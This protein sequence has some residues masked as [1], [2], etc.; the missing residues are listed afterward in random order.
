M[1]GGGSKTTSN[2]DIV[3]NSIISA[4]ISSAQSCT[5]GLT[6]NQTVVSSGL[7]LFT[8]TAQTATVSL[9][10]LQKVVVDDTLLTQ[11]AQQ[12]VQNVQAN[13]G[14]LFGGSANS[15]ANQS[16]K[17]YLQTK[18]T[19]SFVQTC[20]SSISA[21]QSVTTSGVQ[22]GTLDEQTVSTVQ[23]CL[24]NALNSNNVAQGITTDTTQTGAAAN[25]GFSLS[26]GSLGSIGSYV[27]YFIVFIVLIIT[28]WYIYKYYSS[29]KAKTPTPER[30]PEPGTY[31]PE[32][33]TEHII[34]PVSIPTLESL[35]TQEPVQE[36][37]SVSSP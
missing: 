1:G 20:V 32:S 36:P 2:I 31:T 21:N 27:I 24:A 29:S 8:T 23:T 35:H 34:T 19:T 11:M 15:S 22:V 37:I 17:N 4:I 16:V 25:T 3:N 28:G 18:V 14:S 9:T 33:T 5:S 6:A 10:C 12:I 13:N 7:S 30:T 26:L